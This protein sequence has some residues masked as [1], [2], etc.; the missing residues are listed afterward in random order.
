[1]LKKSCVHVLVRISQDLGSIGQP[2]LSRNTLIASKH[3]GLALLINPVPE[4]STLSPKKHIFSFSSQPYKER[5][6][7]SQYHQS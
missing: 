7:K 3:T 6:E 1:M 5:K 2:A 4:Q